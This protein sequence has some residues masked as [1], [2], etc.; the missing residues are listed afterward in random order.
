M[1]MESS[2]QKEGVTD[3]CLNSVTLNCLL[4]TYCAAGVGR[5]PAHQGKA[6][7]KRILK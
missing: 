1:D 2:E 3:F 4:A 5:E 7:A 6:D